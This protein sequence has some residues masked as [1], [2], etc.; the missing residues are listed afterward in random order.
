MASGWGSWKSLHFLDSFGSCRSQVSINCKYWNTIS[1]NYLFESNGGL[2]VIPGAHIKGKR[3]F[4]KVRHKTELDLA[5]RMAD[6]NVFEVSLEET[7]D[8]QH[9]QSQV[10]RYR[11]RAGGAGTRNRFPYGCLLVYDM[12]WIRNTS[13]VYTALQ[14]EQLLWK[15]KAGP[16]LE[17]HG[18]WRT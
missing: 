10:F 15:A 5:N 18:W 2:Q 14:R 6:H 16:N 4:R 9:F 7:K 3:P 13:P 8:I 1:S 12:V 17:V 11:L